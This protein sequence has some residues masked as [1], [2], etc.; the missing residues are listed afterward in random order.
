MKKQEIENR[1]ETALNSLDHVSRIGPGPFFYTRVLARLS[2]K[3]RTSWEKISSFIS[4]PAIAFAV[5]CLVISINTIVIF[6]TEKS[7]IITEQSNL[8]STDDAAESDIIAFYDE[9]TDNMD[10]P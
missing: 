10:T 7:P 1:I 2:R 8:T 3:D 4:Q 9:E 6:Q 5:V